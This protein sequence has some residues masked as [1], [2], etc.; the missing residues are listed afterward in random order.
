MTRPLRSTPTAPSRSFTTTTNRSAGVPTAS[1]LKPLQVM[2][3]GPLPLTTPTPGVDGIGARLPTFHARAADQVHVASM[4]DTAWPVNGTPAR[5]IT[6]AQE[7]PLLMPPELNNDTS[8]ATPS[9]ELRT[10]SLIPT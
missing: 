8:T 1:V 4:P 5:L 9:L 10:V 6:D 2:L 3:L 7:R